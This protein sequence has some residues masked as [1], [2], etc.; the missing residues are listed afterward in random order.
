M[1][2]SPIWH[3]IST[4]LPCKLTST[5]NIVT[6]HFKFCLLPFRPLPPPIPV[7]FLLCPRVCVCVCV[8][9]C[10]CVRACVCAGVVGQYN[11]VLIY[12]FWGFMCTFLFCKPSVA[13]TIVGEI[14]RSRNDRCCYCFHPSSITFLP[15]WFWCFL[16]LTQELQN[17]F[18][19]TVEQRASTREVKC[20]YESVTK[21]VF[22]VFISCC[23]SLYPITRA[24]SECERC[25]RV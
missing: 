14:P 5:N 4:T 15:C 24:V 9:V 21:N 11:I 6:G 18:K 17:I 25:V 8:S 7:A 10:A 22:L 2:F 3:H 16:L 13:F 19:A 20:F 23:L 12:Y 1:G